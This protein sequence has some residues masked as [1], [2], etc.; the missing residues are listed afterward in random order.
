VT[1]FVWIRV[2]FFFGGKSFI[3]QTET[4]RLRMN[5]NDQKR[6]MMKYELEKGLSLLLPPR[7]R[8]HHHHHSLF[9][10]AAAA[11]IVEA[12]VEAEA[13]M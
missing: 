8:R 13:L 10:A 12:I 7:R 11:I 3:E 1:D 4:N 9:C 6:Q 5:W 2:T